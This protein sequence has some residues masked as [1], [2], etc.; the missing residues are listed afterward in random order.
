MQVR[1]VEEEGRVSRGT[2]E[3]RYLFLS[4]EVKG[5]EGDKLNIAIYC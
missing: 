3:E 5:M 2:A 1:A 4:L